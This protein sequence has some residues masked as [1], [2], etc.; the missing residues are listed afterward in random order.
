MG[1]KNNVG[2]GR[3]LL[4]H[5]HKNIVRITFILTNRNV[6]AKVLITTGEG[7]FYSNGID[8]D[9]VASHEGEREQF[10][11]SL[12]DTLWRI[13]HFPLPTVAAIN[14]ESISSKPRK[15]GGGQ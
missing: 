1:K 6:S 2:I 7:R 5:V 11:Q 10:M 12:W 13:M 14:G 9:W 8:L 3:H 4:H 15:G